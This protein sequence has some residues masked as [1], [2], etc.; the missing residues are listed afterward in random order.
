LKENAAVGKRDPATGGGHVE[1]YEV[2]AFQMLTIADSP[3][4]AQDCCGRRAGLIAIDG[5]RPVEP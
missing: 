2:M 1:D 3:A 5:D 4:P